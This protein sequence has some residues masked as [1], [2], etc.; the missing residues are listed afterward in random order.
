MKKHVFA[1]PLELQS[2][3]K[4][5]NYLRGTDEKRNREAG[6]SVRPGFGRASSSGKAALEGRFQKKHRRFPLVAVRK[7]KKEMKKSCEVL[8]VGYWKGSSETRRSAVGTD[9]RE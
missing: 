7:S 2:T 1:C 9:S 3:G 5:G 4:P 8:D 6:V